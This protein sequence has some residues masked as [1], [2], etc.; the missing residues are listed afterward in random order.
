MGGLLL[1]SCF[2][3]RLSASD[4]DSAGGLGTVGALSSGTCSSV[5]LASCPS[6]DWGES[7]A[8]GET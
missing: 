4:S 2:S 7:F 6:A 8:A 1:L 3:S 5:G